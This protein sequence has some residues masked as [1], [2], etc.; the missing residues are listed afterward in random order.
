M[1]QTMSYI[2]SILG[3]ISSVVAS[4]VKGK[5]MKAILFLLFLGN[6]LIATSYLVGGTG[7]NGA[8]SCYIGGAQCI[9]NYFYDSK[10][11]PLPKWLICSYAATYICLNLGFALYLGQFS[12]LTVLA[13][14]ACLIF[15]MCIGQKNG[16][17]Y[18]FW[19]IADMLLWCLY[20]I[21]S[22]SYG[23][24]ITHGVQIFFSI[25]GI[26]IHDVKNRERG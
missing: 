12:Y 3:L 14:I 22:V 20:D 1:C 24:L 5:N 16:Y 8:V 13:V 11:K 18:R 23:A 2:L 25:I 15:I 10:N 7:I 6:I 26:L 17:K 9:I 19:T 21:L 4:L